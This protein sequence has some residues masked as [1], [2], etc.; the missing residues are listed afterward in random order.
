MHL[1]VTRP[2]AALTSP[3]ILRRSKWP[4][5]RI[6]QIGIVLAIQYEVQ[7]ERSVVWIEFWPPQV[8]DFLLVLPPEQL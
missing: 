3:R 5:K 6:A 1:L 7:N 4:Q 8:R 2:F